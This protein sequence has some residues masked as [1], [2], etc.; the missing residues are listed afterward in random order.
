[1]PKCFTKTTPE[2]KVDL[3]QKLSDK[4][5]IYVFYNYESKQIQHEAAKLLYQR[6]WIY[7]FEEYLWFYKVNPN[8]LS[9]LQFF[10]IKRWE[11]QPYQYELRKDQFAKLEDFENC[12][13]I[14]EN[15]ISSN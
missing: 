6:E 1:M 12:M 2:L 15:I 8:D 11:L 7:N 10:N 5:L 4:T 9:N 3:I 13:K 14:K